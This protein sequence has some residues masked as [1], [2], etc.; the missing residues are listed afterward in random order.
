MKYRSLITATVVAFQCGVFALPTIAATA[1]GETRVPAARASPPG[2]GVSAVIARL[3][4]GM[5]DVKTFPSPNGM[6]GVVAKGN[7]KPVMMFV[8]PQGRMVIYGIGFDLAK[9]AV[10]GAAEI[11]ADFKVSGSQLPAP[12]G[13][14]ASGDQVVHADVLAK[15]KAS[16][17]IE[18]VSGNGKGPLIY[19]FVEPNCVWCKR[20][21][22]AMT[23]SQK[24]P[25]TVLGNAT[26]RWIPLAFTEDGFQQAVSALRSQAEGFEKLNQMFNTP[27]QPFDAHGDP[28]YQQITAN[29]AL[30]QA[31]GDTG[32]PTFY[33]LARADATSGK[34][35]EGWGGLELFKQ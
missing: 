32:T 15:L 30:F 13:A 18:T 27:V 7:G 31:L 35:I 29:I 26:V 3:T 22:P 1:G 8:D 4:A 11:Q 23:T 16:T 20:A 21:W 34:R 6:I 10:V 17:Y 19:A 9:N 33:E 25:G 12:G 5:T 24:S 28:S 2:S 14:Q